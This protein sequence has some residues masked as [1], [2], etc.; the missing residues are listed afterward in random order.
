[1]SMYEDYCLIRVIGKLENVNWLCHYIQELA[2]M[3][4]PS[5]N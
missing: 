3:A 4:V 1:M 2:C 5:A